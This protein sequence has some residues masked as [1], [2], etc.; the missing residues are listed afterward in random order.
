MNGENN[1][2]AIKD[3]I[4]AYKLPLDTQDIEKNKN[5]NKKGVS[6]KFKYLFPLELLVYY[7]ELNCDVRENTF[8]FNKEAYKRASLNHSMTFFLDV[9][10]DYY[11]VSKKNYALNCVNYNKFL[12]ILRQVCKLH[13]IQ[14]DKHTT[15]FRSS[16]VI[17]YLIECKTVVP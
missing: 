1:T 11:H 15:Y 10:L 9:I 17:S 2:D 14:F 3:K 13:S 6:D 7:L 4:Y 8:V 12:T 16:H 5:K